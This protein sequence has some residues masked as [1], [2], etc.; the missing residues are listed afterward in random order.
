MSRSGFER[1]EMPD[2]QVV[3]VAQ[4]QRFTTGEKLRILEKAEACTDQARSAPSWDV[5]ALRVDFETSRAT[6]TGG[7]L[8]W[9][10]ASHGTLT[11]LAIISR[12][13]HAYRTPLFRWNRTSKAH[14]GGSK[15]SVSGLPPL[16]C[17]IHDLKPGSF[18][19][20]LGVV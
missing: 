18:P 3:P 6:R 8:P 12:S 9:S 4:R 5:Q 17:D 15:F 11:R 13:V 2:P 14:S 20:I 1:T 16:E 10:T 19:K 7:V